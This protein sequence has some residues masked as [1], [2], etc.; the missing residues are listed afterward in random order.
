[1]VD[2]EKC[3]SAARVT[4]SSSPATPVN[5]F[6]GDGNGHLRLRVDGG[7][8]AGMGNRD[9]D[10][11]FPGRQSYRPRLEQPG[12]R[13]PIDF[14]FQD[15]S[16]R[17]FVLIGAQ[18]QTQTGQF[19]SGTGIGQQVPICRGTSIT[20]PTPGS[21][22]AHRPLPA[23]RPGIR[24]SLRARAA[25]AVPRWLGEASA[26]TAVAQRPASSS[27]GAVDEQQSHR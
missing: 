18:D 21:G 17:H 10:H 15:P 3:E 14:A 7:T 13:R 11:G 20:M 5:I 12:V 2:V 24:A 22:S 1:M 4:M 16:I 19:P 9:E 27:P 23:A 25:P 6:V 8:W 26:A